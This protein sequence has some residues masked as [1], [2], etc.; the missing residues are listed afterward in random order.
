MPLNCKKGVLDASSSGG[1]L[2]GKR[3]SVNFLIEEID[4]DKLVLKA[5]KG[6]RKAYG[7]LIHMH[8][9]YLY[10]TA[11]LYLK[12]EDSALDIVQ[13]CILKGFQTI[14]NLR[15]PEYFRT[16]LTRILIN[17]AKAS[18]KK[19]VSFTPIDT[20]EDIASESTSSIE[21]K[22]DL[23]D[24]IELL[25]ENYRTIVILKYFND[26][27]ISEIASTMDIPEGSV[28]AYLSR[29]KQELRLCL[30][31]DYIYDN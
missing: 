19:N 23:Y 25:P 10:R 4:V 5:I 13:D 16:W 18:F 11:Y 14:K 31:E 29:A 1:Q 3:G 12:N 26:L 17:L 2:N 20:I 7:Q 28:K 8:K 15:Q 6:N 9:D 22:W 24:A 30:K 27:K 21:E